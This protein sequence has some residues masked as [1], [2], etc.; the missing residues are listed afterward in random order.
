MGVRRLRNS[1][2]SAFRFLFLFSYFFVARMNEVKSGIG[3]QASWSSPD[4]ASL[5]RATPRLIVMDPA[6]HCR[7]PSDE[8]RICGEVLA[9]AL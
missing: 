3:I 8:D 1:V 4:V 2:L 7:I 9:L 6:L 5:I